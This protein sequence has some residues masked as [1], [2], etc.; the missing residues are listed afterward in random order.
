MIT[1]CTQENTVVALF[2]NNNN[3]NNNRLNIKY[4]TRT[5]DVT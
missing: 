4:S 3:V 1:N 5:E 2:N